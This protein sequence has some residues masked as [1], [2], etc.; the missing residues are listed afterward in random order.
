M[1]VVNDETRKNLIKETK[2]WLEKIKKERENIALKDSMHTDFLENIDAYISDSEFF[3]ENGDLI[4]AFEA[5]IWSWAYLEI[6]KDMKILE[7]KK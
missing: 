2:K 3:L 7:N 4:E 6:G 5:V 1:K